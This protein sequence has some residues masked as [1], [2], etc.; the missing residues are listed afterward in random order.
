M[1]FGGI[2]AFFA[3]LDLVVGCF[4]VARDHHDL[5]RNFSGLE[6]QIIAAGK[7]ITEK[8]LNEFVVRRLEI[9]EDEPPQLRV[10]NV[11][12]HNDV[13]KALGSDKK[14]LVHVGFWTRLTSDICDFGA[15][16]LERQ[17]DRLEKAET[18][19]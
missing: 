12:C 18:S 8:Q 14:Y 1:I 19:I 16:N 2:V 6:R 4:N 13:V 11:L 5:I 7:D 3:A 10:L 9:E 17:M 15:D